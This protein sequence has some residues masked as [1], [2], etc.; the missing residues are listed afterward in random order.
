[1]HSKPALFPYALSFWKKKKVFS[2]VLVLFWAC[3]SHAQNAKVE[4]L[5]DSISQIRQQPQFS[6]KDTTHINLLNQLAVSLR[7]YEVE[8]AYTIAKK[9]LQLSQEANYDLGKATALLRIGDY[10]SDMGQSDKAIESFEQ[11][12]EIANDLDD[13]MIPLRIINNLASEHTYQGDFAEAL[14]DYLHGIERI[15]AKL[16]K[17]RDKDLLVILSIMNENIANLF[18]SQRD[19]EQSLK[20]FEKVRKINIEIGEAV[21]MAET[22]SNL[23]SVYAEKGATDEGVSKDFDYAMFHIN[24]SIQTF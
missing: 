1:M 15:H 23:A 20:Y 10:H 5:Y 6:E 17:E 9:A 13:K 3:I 21:T 11:A 8:N 14:K 12:L 22:N 19:Y 4:Q 2:I 7:Y 16:E 24:S 18:A